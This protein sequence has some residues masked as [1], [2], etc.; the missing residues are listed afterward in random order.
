MTH[1]VAFLVYPGF[2]LLNLSG[3]ASVFDAANLELRM[4]G[5]KPLYAIEVL[6][7]T[8]GLVMSNGGI[9]VQTRALA[10]MPATQVHTA[11]FVGAYM[12][13]LLALTLEPSVRRWAIRCARAATRFGAVCTGA[14]VLAA[15]GLLDGKRAA[16]HWFACALLAENYPSVTVDPDA[17]YVVDGKTWTSAGASAGIDMALGMVSRDL[18]DSMASQV[19]KG[20]VVYARRPGYQSQFSPLLLAQAKADGPF[21]ELTNWLQANLHRPLDVPNLATR[22]GLSERT[23]Y[24][25]FVAATGESPARFIEAVRLDAA[26]ML[27][28]QGLTLK[29]IAA[30]VGLM[31]TARLT[32]A[33]ERRFGVSPSLFRE[34]HTSALD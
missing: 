29:A 5:R 30:Q 20:L 8:G 13:H 27:L 1:T 14:F 23:F 18:G 12:E 4:S 34:M 6:S 17:L 32:R 25:K 33:F 22:V 15:L 7:P 26:R 21:A 11:L 28:S 9:T 16:T 2:S 31:P 10:R 3:P 24:R 19:A